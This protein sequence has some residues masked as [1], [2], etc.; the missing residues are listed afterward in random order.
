MLLPLQAQL[1]SL[2][3]P[4]SQPRGLQALWIEGQDSPCSVTD[5]STVL[6]AAQHH[7]Q[8]P[9]RAVGTLSWGMPCSAPTGN[10]VPHLLEL[11]EGSES[12]ACPFP[13]RFSL[14]HSGRTVTDIP[15]QMLRQK[16]C[17]NRPFSPRSPHPLPC[18]VASG[19]AGASQHHGAFPCHSVF[20]RGS[21]G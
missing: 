18:P 4:G 11:S 2:L 15:C 17:S 9:A 13:P 16:F 19:L 12:E 1:C 3:E 14:R 5:H 10:P 6:A 20:S 8:P 21:G 7:L